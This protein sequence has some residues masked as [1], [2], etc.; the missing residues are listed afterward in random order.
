MKDKKFDALLEFI[1]TGFYFGKSP[2]V[3]GTVGS[4]SAIPL[5]YLFGNNIFEK[6]LFFIIFIPLGIKSAQF[7]IDKTQSQDPDEI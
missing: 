3:P 6:L 5:I 2:I 1:A 7:M 4:L